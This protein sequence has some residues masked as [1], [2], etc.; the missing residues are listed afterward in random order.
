MTRTKG[1]LLMTGVIVALSLSRPAE[2]WVAY[3]GCPSY[4]AYGRPAPWYGSSGSAT[5]RYGGSVSWSR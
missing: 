3:H 4:R 5:G 1:L 2:A